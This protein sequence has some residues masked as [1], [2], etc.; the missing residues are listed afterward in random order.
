MVR[1]PNVSQDKLN[2]W[3]DELKES[4]QATF[5][6]SGP[7]SGTINAVHKI[8][9]FCVNIKAAY[10]L[11]SDGSLTISSNHGEDQIRQE[12]L[13]RLGRTV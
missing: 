1:I 7:T 3:M 11:M 12:I 4:G 2:E 6:S 9:I 10:N 5:S 13:T 8:G